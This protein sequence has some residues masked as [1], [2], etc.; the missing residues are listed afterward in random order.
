M[1]KAKNNIEMVLPF[2]ASSAEAEN[3]N[4]ISKIFE[5]SFKTERKAALLSCKPNLFISLFV[6]SVIIYSGM[7]KARG[8]II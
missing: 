5:T 7:V 4:T 8:K 2:I 6:I 1:A 3:K